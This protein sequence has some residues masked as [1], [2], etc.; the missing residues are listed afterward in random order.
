MAAVPPPKRARLVG[1]DNFVRSNPKSDRFE[2]QKF[3]HL[4]L[5]CGDAKSTANFLCTAL[6]LRPI[7]ASSAATCRTSSWSPPLLC[8]WRSRHC[9]TSATVWA[10]TA[11]TPRVH[12]S[13]TLRE[14]AFLM[15]WLVCGV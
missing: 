12:R 1:F 6:G 14:H 13:M 15:E 4:E 8:S 3:H 9:R 10:R 11:T 5:Y 2:V 7:A